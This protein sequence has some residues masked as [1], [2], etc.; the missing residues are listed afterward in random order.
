MNNKVL[1]REEAIILATNSI[2]EDSIVISTTGMVSRELYEFR[3][4]K[5]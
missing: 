5:S 3:A 2:K 1:E 4:K